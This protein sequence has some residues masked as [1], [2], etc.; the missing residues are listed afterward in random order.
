LI[1]TR[2]VGLI[3]LFRG[4]VD[5]SHVELLSTEKPAWYNAHRVD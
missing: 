2:V 3:H 4:D 1:D 5:F